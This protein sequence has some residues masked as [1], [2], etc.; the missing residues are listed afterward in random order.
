MEFLPTRQGPVTKVEFSDAHAFHIDEAVR[1]AECLHHHH[2]PQEF[3]QIIEVIHIG[4]ID[5]ILFPY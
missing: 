3:G 1:L 4:K 2:R 5:V